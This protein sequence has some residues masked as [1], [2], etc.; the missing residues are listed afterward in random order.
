MAVVI[1]VLL[2]IVIILMVVIVI[3]LETKLSLPGAFLN[4]LR[5]RGSSR[6]KGKSGGDKGKSG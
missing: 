4:V 2:V 1:V 5:T 6:D 3:V